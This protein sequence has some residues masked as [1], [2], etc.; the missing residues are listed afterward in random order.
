MKQRVEDTSRISREAPRVPI[1]TAAE[2][3][4][5]TA[6]RVA[7]AKLY[8]RVPLPKASVGLLAVSP[9]PPPKKVDAMAR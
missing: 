3:A 8:C 7:A 1:A 4:V 2:E 5:A 9:P 6:V